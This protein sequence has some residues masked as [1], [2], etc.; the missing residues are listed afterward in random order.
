MAKHFINTADE[1][2]KMAQKAGVT[3]EE[4]SRLAYAANLSGVQA[5]GLKNAFK[6][7]NEQLVAAN[8]GSPETLQL[9]KDLGVT[10]RDSATVLS[11]IAQ[12]F[13][14]TADGA[15]KSAAAVKVVRSRR[16]RHDSFPEP[17]RGGYSG[18]D[19]RG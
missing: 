19:A 11:Q 17:R 13:A 12:K 7:L 4:F 18:I 1:M 10:G 9:F 14:D 5:D 6:F 8:Q 3:T 16:S 15:D 2:G